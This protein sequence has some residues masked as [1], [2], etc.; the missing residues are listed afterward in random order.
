MSAADRAARNGQ[1]PPAEKDWPYYD[2]KTDARGIALITN[3]PA[4]S[5]AGVTTPREYY[6]GA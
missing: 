5:K 6:F 1:K 2:K 4:D 3:L